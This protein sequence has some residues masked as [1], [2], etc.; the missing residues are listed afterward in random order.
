MAIKE[1][2]RTG[3]WF[4]MILLPA[5]VMIISLFMCSGAFAEN[6]NYILP[7]SAWRNYSSAEIADMPLQV[8]CYAKNEIYARNGRMFV[9][10]ELQNYFNSQYWYTPIYRP[11]QFTPDMLNTYE[12]ANVGLL[13]AREKALGTYSLDVAGYSYQVV[14]NYILSHT[15][16]AGG[17][18]SGGYPY[19]V[20]PN[21]YIIADSNTRYLSDAE[22]SGMSLQE[23]CYAKNEIYARRGRRFVSQELQNYFNLRNWY[24]GSIAPEAFS[25][26]VFTDVEM[27]NVNKLS[28][29][30]NARG[31]YAL[32][33]PGYAY[34]NVRSFSSAGGS[35]ALSG[36]TVSTSDFIFWDS[37]IRYLTDAEVAA[38]SL[39]QMCYARNEIY[40]RRGYIFN[41]QELRDYFGSKSWYFGTIPSGSFS[42]SVFNTYEMANVELLKRYEYA[43]APNGYQ[44]Y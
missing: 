34:E 21:G 32:D 28:A 13:D 37:S 9:S 14:Y 35:Q 39:Q 19:G 7:D 6:Y 22:I 8:V 3:S 18:S 44:L 12:T 31:T 11:E 42:S 29:L 17:Q 23:L 30:E 25:D 4:R 20:D 33:V 26:S 40:A 36:R 2:N 1:K 15:G 16:T 27:T 5:A 41:S 38:L 10:A 43:I 24:N